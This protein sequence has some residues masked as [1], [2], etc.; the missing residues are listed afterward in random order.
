LLARWCPEL[1][2][3]KVTRLIYL[4]D[5]ISTIPNGKEI[6]SRD[7]MNGLGMMR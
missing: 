2:F 1:L 4:I 7:H 5:I 3:C 6:S